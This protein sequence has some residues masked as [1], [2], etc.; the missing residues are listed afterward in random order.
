MGSKSKKKKHRKDVTPPPSQDE[1]RRRNRE[2]R[3]RHNEPS[4]SSS[5]FKSHHHRDQKRQRNNSEEYRPSKTTKIDSDDDEEVD[6]SFE[7]Y[8]YELNMIF[9]RDG[10]LIKQGTDE[11]RDFWDFLKNYLGSQKRL[12]KQY[13]PPQPCEEER[14]LGI[15]IVF[16]KSHAVAVGMKANT[17]ELMSRMPPRDR[18]SGRWLSKK[19]ISE[20]R[21]IF[22]MYLDFKQKEKFKKLKTLRDAQTT[23]PVHHYK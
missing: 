3:D 13:Q 21:D 17:E 9:F 18:S 5:S 11:Y 7:K 16:N 19:R 4:S 10:D 1:D 20:F 15:P 12:G 14:D 8:K 6:F 2:R 22:L 23:L